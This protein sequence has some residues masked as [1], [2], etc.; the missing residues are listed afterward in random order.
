MVVMNSLIKRSLLTVTIFTLL[1][2]CAKQSELSNAE[3]IRNAYLDVIEATEAKIRP[4]VNLTKDDENITWNEAQDRVLLFTFHRYPDS[5]PDGEE[6]TFTWGESWL[7]SVKEYAKW[8]KENK[9][10]IKNV[11]LRT[12]QVLGMD[13]ESKNTYI[14][15]M[16]FDVKDLSRPAYVT[17][18]TKPMKLEFDESASEEYKT[19]FSSQYY[20]SYDV[21]HLPWTRLGYTYDWSKEAKDRY[22]LSEFIAW[23][24]TTVTVDKTLLVEDFVKTL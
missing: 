20:Y 1:G 19:W 22:G 14:S 21:K 16:W 10:N 24:G 11:L 4:L 5:Y 23:K 3:L 12:K 9:S 7:C 15:S 6:I 13:E 18:P 2:G 17:D 8:Y